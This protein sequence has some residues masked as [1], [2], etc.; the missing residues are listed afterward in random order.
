MGTSKDAKHRFKLWQL[1]SAALKMRTRQGRTEK[2]KGGWG[3]NPFLAAKIVPV[4]WDLYDWYSGVGGA[5]MLF[6]FWCS[7]VCVFVVVGSLS[8]KVT[9]VRTQ[10]QRV[11]SCF[12]PDPPALP[13]PQGR[14]S[15]GSVTAPAIRSLNV[16]AASLPFSLT[17]W[18]TRCPPTPGN[19][20]RLQLDD[21]RDS[22]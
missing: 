16:C 18:G 22:D 15:I 1:I 17:H 8:L 10:P 20:L 3:K 6:P 9:G 2:K 11:G 12:V 19:W 5:G 4:Q 21:P 13:T 14:C 7:I